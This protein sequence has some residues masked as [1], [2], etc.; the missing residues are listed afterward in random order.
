MPSRTRRSH[1]LALV[2]LVL[3][4]PGRLSVWGRG[5]RLGPFGRHVHRF[6]HHGCDESD[7]YMSG[8]EDDKTAPD[9]QVRLGSWMVFWRGLTKAE[10]MTGMLSLKRSPRLLRS[11]AARTCY[12][13]ASRTFP[14]Q[15]TSCWP[16][17]AR[18][19]LCGAKSP[20]QHSKASGQFL[21]QRSRQGPFV[22]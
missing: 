5:Q 6:I 19:C 11:A 3:A 4:V 8:H 20:G 22:G 12:C 17:S 21:D 16:G 10:N 18:T 9:T 13:P 1:A 14:S 15:R 2:L 7:G